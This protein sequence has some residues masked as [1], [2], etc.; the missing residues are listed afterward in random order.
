MFA[1]IIS[2][3]STRISNP[4]A[5]TT[6]FLKQ[7]QTKKK[8]ALTGTP[9][10]NSP[11]DLYS[12][13]DWLS[14][15]FLGTYYQFVSRYCITDAR[16]PSMILGYQN[17]SELKWRVSR[18]ILRRSK[19][20]VFTDFPSKTISNIVFDLSEEERELYDNIRNLIWEELEALTIT[21][22]SLATIPVKMLR[23]KQ[24]TDHPALIS[25]LKK[26]SKMETLQEL[27]K[28]IVESGEK[29]IIFSQFAEM[30][31][32]ILDETSASLIIHGE[33][34]SEK[35]Q[36]IVNLFNTE[37]FYRVLIMTEAGA[38]GLNLQAASYVIH[39]DSPWSVA[40]LMQR[41]DRAHRIGQTKS[42]TVYNLIARKTIDEYVLKKL[43]KKQ[44]LAVE[45]LQ[46]VERLEAQGI[47]EEDIKSI[48]RI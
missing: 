7:L 36:Q 15:R 28:G 2:D 6:K 22:Q 12:I 27:L 13:I 5:K 8:I 47:D 35:R 25:D 26:S 43:H 11:N 30:A 9:I 31:T 14:P 32:K 46:D 44:K 17:L 38:Y 10:S 42:V 21:K 40:K 34:P 19:E 33:V 1:A 41:E 45:L 20:E 39:Y 3:E 23:L 24:A 48:L 18:F 29:V 4:S 37:P 16:Y